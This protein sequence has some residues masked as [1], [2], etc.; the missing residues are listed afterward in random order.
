MA[1]LLIHIGLGGAVAASGAL[2][3]GLVALGFRMFL[4]KGARAQQ[5]QRIRQI[6]LVGSM[7]QAL[8]DV[9]QPELNFPKRATN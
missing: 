5:L 6:G 4:T 7:K 2:V 8:F 9:P 3:G 1:S